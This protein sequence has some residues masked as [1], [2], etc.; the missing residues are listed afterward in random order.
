VSP[1]SFLFIY[2]WLRSSQTICQLRHR[3][4][5]HWACG[6]GIEYLDIHPPLKE[7]ASDEN[8]R[9]FQGVGNERMECLG[10]KV[11]AAERA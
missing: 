3:P 6:S 10:G 1:Q 8:G 11:E 4:I 9:P 7:W 2:S 5:D